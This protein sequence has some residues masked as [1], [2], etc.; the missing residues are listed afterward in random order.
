MLSSAV[1][2]DLTPWGCAVGPEWEKVFTLVRAAEWQIA[3]VELLI[4][5]YCVDNKGSYWAGWSGKTLAIM[6]NVAH[7]LRGKRRRQRGDLIWQQQ[8]Y[9]LAFADVRSRPATIGFWPG[10]RRA[11]ASRSCR[12][13]GIWP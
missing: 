7:A 2:P 8:L 9:L 1:Q 5:N 10:L 6:Q 13:T 3:S 12:G 4:W 11:A